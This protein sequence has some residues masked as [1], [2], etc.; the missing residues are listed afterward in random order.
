M[1]R[2]LDKMQS[3]LSILVNHSYESVMRRRLKNHN[4]SIICSNCA[5]GGNI[6]QI[7]RKIPF[8]DGKFVA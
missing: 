6:S 7:G 2:C 1:G 3:V 5:G 4:F 8:P